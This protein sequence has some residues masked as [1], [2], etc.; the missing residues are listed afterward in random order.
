METL[1][2]KLE[3][4]INIESGMTDALNFFM[5]RGKS[6]EIEF[7]NMDR[8]MLRSWMESDMVIPAKRHWN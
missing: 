1:S 3:V 4:R 6:F 5:V 2:K 7:S 8:K